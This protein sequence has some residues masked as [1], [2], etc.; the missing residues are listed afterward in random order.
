M[1]VQLGME[2]TNSNGHGGVKE[3]EI[4][5][6]ETLRKLQTDVQIHKVDNERL[7]NAKEQ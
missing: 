3:E 6:D 2:G 5:M 7:M 4:N 1:N